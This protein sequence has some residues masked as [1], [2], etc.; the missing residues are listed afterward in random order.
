[1]GY[2]RSNSEEVFAITGLVASIVAILQSSRCN[3]GLA[4]T[5]VPNGV[6]ST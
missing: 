3:D 2:H 1:M 6:R 4:A 5:S